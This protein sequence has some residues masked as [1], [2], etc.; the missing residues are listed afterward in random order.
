MA[1][2]SNARGLVPKVLARGI[3]DHTKIDAGA[4]GRHK[5]LAWRAWRSAREAQPIP[6][7]IVD[8]LWSDTVGHGG[9]GARYRGKNVQ[10]VGNF[11]S[12][13]VGSA[14]VAARA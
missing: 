5:S 9:R 13:V 6:L 14:A 10:A 11:V 3:A 2:S 7:A 1:Y 12:A 8:R 4:V